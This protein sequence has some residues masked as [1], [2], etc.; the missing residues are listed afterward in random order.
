MFASISKLFRKSGRDK[1]E[2]PSSSAPGGAFPAQPSADSEGGVDAAGESI[3]ISYLVIL[4]AVPHNLHGKNAA[5]TAA[6]GK[7]FI[8]RQEVIDQLAQGAVRI[9]F[10]SFRS[11]AP[12][13]TFTTSAAQ[14]STLIELPLA[15]LVPQLKKSF[16]RTPKKRIE[17]PSEVADVFGAK[18]AGIR[19]LAK[20]EAKAMAGP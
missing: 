10:G 17:V 16:I 14:D 13:G 19:V 11:V 2:Q 6:T 7:F 15:D 18:G 3:S 5:S 4:K 12:P 20:Q 8:P 1:A 9:A